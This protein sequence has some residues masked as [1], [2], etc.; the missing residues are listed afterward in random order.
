LKICALIREE[1]TDLSFVKCNVMNHMNQS[2][3]GSRCHQQLLMRSRQRRHDAAL[4][5]ANPTMSK[6]RKTTDIGKRLIDAAAEKARRTAA[7]A[8]DAAAEEA[9]WRCELSPEEEEIY[10]IHDALPFIRQ[11]PSRLR[12][13]VTATVRG[14]APRSYAKAIRLG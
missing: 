6:T 5:F 13:A 10:A 9:F 2:V 14:V 8:R 4:T 12:V 1:F 11:L 7:E 3:N